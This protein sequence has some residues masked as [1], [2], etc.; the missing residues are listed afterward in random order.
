MSDDIPIDD[1]SVKYVVSTCSFE[2]LLNND[3]VDRTLNEVQR[4]LSGD[5]LF[6]LYFLTD[7]DGFYGPHIHETEDGYSLA[8]VDDTRMTIRMYSIDEMKRLI[9]NKF[10]I[11]SENTF[12]FTDSRSG[13][14]YVRNIHGLIAK[15]V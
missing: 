10:S 7:K 4:V 5:G 12:I 9:S 3:D 11:V 6:F 1:M 15:P 8:T 2:N 13:K 14:D